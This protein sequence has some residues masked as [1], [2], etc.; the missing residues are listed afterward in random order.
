M[1]LGLVHVELVGCGFVGGGLL[2]GFWVFGVR[3]PPTQTSKQHDTHRTPRALASH[4]RLLNVLVPV[5]ARGSRHLKTELGASDADELILGF[6]FLLA[7]LRVKKVH[8][9]QNSCN[10]HGR[11]KGSCKGSPCLILSW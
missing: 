11:H 9:S 6:G 1:G 7:S 5:G 2:V 8:H 4:Q 3:V 10:N